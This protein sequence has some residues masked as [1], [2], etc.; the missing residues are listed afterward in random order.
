[1]LQLQMVL[2]KSGPIFLSDIANEFSL[3][4]NVRM[5]QLY[6]NGGVVPNN[7]GS[8]A[9]VP[10][11]GTSRVS[12]FFG[13]AG[14]NQTGQVSI[15]INA[16]FVTV[17]GDPAIRAQFETD[18]R[19]SLAEQVGLPLG[20]VTVALTPGSII[21]T[22]QVTLPAT[23]LVNAS[24]TV[25]IVALEA[26]TSLSAVFGTAFATTYGMQANAA[27][28]VTARVPPR[29]LLNGAF[30]LG[31]TSVSTGT[32]SCP[33][34]SLFESPAESSM[35]ITYVV[36]NGSSYSN[37]TVVGSNLSFSLAGRN[38]T[39][40]VSAR[41]IDVNGIASSDFPITVIP[42][43]SPRSSPHC[44]RTSTWSGILLW[45]TRHSI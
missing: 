32:I 39:Y 37:A 17:V 41:A 45:C 5:S 4:G 30:T 31:S 3:V 44:L 36:N 26:A 16:D 23:G 35:P 13:C 14:M 7:S 2:T 12:M 42:C 1:M 24:A 28:T 18:V 11:S 8:N 43:E 20:N 15:T 6:Q 29:L 25:K 33:L 40:K 22:F 27:T 38:A 9:T 10:L 19:R 21:A 34:D